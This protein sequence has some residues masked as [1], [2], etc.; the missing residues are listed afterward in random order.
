MSG[1]I[2]YNHYLGIDDTTSKDLN[3]FFARLNASGEFN[4]D[5]FVR[6]SFNQKFRHSYTS[7]DQSMTGINKNVNN[8]FKLSTSFV[9]AEETLLLKITGGYNLSRY[10]DEAGVDSNNLDTVSGV[11]YG[12]RKILPKTALF[13]NNT[14]KYHIYKNEE[15]NSMP[16]T[17]HGGVIGQ[18]TSKI[19]LKLSGGY[20]NTFSENAKNDFLGNV[21]IVSR[22]SINSMVKIGFLKTY[23]PSKSF[24]YLAKNKI[25]LTLSQKFLRKGVLGFNGSYSFDSYGKN[26][27]AVK[28]TSGIYESKIYLSNDSVTKT[29]S[30]DTR[31][32]NMIKLSAFTAYDINDWFGL[33]LNYNY[34]KKDSDY[35]QTSSATDPSSATTD[36]SEQK[37]YVDKVVQKITLSFTVD[38]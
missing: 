13:I 37:T 19:A 32:E 23:L 12:N 20:I 10:L 36:R 33:K 15:L 25:Y 29:Y 26:L 34:E 24:Q 14:I 21:E 9:S 6:F 28:S 5:S 22:F 8:D 7:K 38:Y 1:Q 16:L 4:R 11:I 2:D 31:S 35:Y 3:S 17:I 27:D 30:S 18:L